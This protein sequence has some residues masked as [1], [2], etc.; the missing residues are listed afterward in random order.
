[1]YCAIG[2]VGG[3]IA[4]QG[5]WVGLLC[6]RVRLFSYCTIGSAGGLHSRQSALPLSYQ[7][8]MKVHVYRTPEKEKGKKE[9]GE[10]KKP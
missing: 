10:K 9:K 7:G 6:N 8:Y 2:S 5:Q 3:A 4:Q 1:M